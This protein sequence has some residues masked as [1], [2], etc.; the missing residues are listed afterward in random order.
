MSFFAYDLWAQGS[1]EYMISL[2]HNIA[3]FREVLSG[4]RN[5]EIHIRLALSY[6]QTWLGSLT[7][8]SD[9]AS[10]QVAL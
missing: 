2:A 4:K 10:L 3:S 9:G 1:V 7:V 6:H 8:S 5:T